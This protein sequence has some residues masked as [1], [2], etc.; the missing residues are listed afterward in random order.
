MLDSSAP[1]VLDRAQCL[2]LLRTAPIGRVVFT[3][4]GL[5][6]VQPVRFLLNGDCVCFPAPADSALFA[7]ANDSVIAFEADSFAPDLTEGWCVTVLGRAG[8]DT[9]PDPLSGLPGLR[10]EYP[11][12]DDRRIRLPA[13][14][15]NGRRLQG[16]GWQ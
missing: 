2:A 11:A 5:P 7:A 10:W 1:E 14:V 9:A 12:T 13:E 6:A 4:R 15:V 16:L 8:E 3:N